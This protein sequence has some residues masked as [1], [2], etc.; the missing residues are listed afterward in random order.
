MKTKKKNKSKRTNLRL[1]HHTGAGARARHAPAE[2]GDDC[3][4]HLGMGLSFLDQND[5]SVTSKKGLEVS[6]FRCEF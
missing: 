5:P 1:A 3:G 6:R 2:G 4:G